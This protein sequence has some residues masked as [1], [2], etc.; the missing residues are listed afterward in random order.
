MKT[1]TILFPVLALLTWPVLALDTARIDEITGLKGSLNEEEKVFKVT[2]PRGDLG[3][4]VDEWKMPAS[5]SVAHHP[6]HR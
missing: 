1:T 6:V 3:I 5:M 4:T 2:L